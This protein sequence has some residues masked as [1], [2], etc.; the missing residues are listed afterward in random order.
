MKLPGVCASKARGFTHAP[1]SLEKNGAGFTLVELL[2]VLGILALLMVVSLPL[3]ADFYNNQQFDAQEQG[4][5]QALRRA[6]SKAMAQEL[7]SQFGVYIAFNQYILF[8][9][10][11]YEGRDAN[12]DE[13]FDLP[14]SFQVSGLSEIVFDKLTGATSDTGT[15]TLTIN[16]K[17]EIININEMGRINY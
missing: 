4:I 2:L 5:V 7:D 9:G 15:V 3:A 6:Q 1:F 14:G 17:T 12:F 13:T 8:K 11:S 10:S 16:N